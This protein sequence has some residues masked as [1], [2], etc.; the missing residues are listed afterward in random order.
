MD[1]RLYRLAGIRA[2]KKGMAQRAARSHDGS[3][4]RL[5][6]DGVPR[7]HLRYH[8]RESPVSIQLVAR[9]GRGCGGGDRASLRGGFLYL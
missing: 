1:G 9:V 2:I 6:V 3:H 5:L 4:D 7:H 8:R